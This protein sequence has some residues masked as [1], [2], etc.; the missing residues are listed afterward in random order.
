LESLL[1]HLNCTLKVMFFSGPS[2]A[3]NTTLVTH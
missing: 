3:G 2:E 1:G